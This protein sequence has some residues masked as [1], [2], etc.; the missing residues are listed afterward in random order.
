MKPIFLIGLAALLAALPMASGDTAAIQEMRADRKSTETVD[1]TI[2]YLIDYVAKSNCTFLRNGDPHV[3][4]EAAAH[5]QS[6]YDYFKDKIKTPEDFIQKAAT[7]S[8][9]TGQPYLIK[10]PDGRTIPCAQWL[11]KILA[12]HRKR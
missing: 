1:E 10:T 11:G 5:F 2:R 9:L 4:K 8:M 3:G 6:K 12:D 7:Q